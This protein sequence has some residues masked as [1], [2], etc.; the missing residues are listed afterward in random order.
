MH[1]MIMEET[2]EGATEIIMEYCQSIALATPNINRGKLP[3]RDELNKIYDLL[4]D[5]RRN[6]SA[7]YAIEHLEKKYSRIEY[8]MRHAM[9]SETLAIRGEGYLLHVERLFSEMFSPHDSF[10]EKHYGFKAID[11]VKTFKQLESSFT[12]RVASPNGEPHPFFRFKLEQWHLQ[13]VGKGKYPE[14][15]AKANPGI[16]IEDGKLMLYPLNWISYYKQLY[17]VR[18]F[19]S[20]QEKVVKCLSLRFGENQIFSGFQSYN[21]LNPSEIFTKPLVEDEDGNFYLFAMNIGARNYFNIAQNLIKQAD[22]KYYNQ[23]FIGNAKHISKDRFIER[24]VLSLLKKMLPGV[25]FYPNVKY[26]YAEDDF[27][28]KC[29]KV[30]GSKYELD[31][32]GVSTK[33]TY[34]VEV[35][36]GLINEDS[37]RGAIK[38]IKSDMSKVVGDAV[39]QSYRAYRYIRNTDNCIFTTEEKNEITPLRRDNVFRISV[40]FSYVGSLISALIKL[41]EFGAIDS[42]AEYAWTINIFDLIPFS[43]IV[44]SEDEFID[45]LT[46]R[47]QSYEDK[48]LQV[49]DE[50]DMLG[51]YYENDL[52]IDPAFDNSDTVILNGYKDAIDDYFEGRGPKPKKKT[53]TVL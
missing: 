46:K 2:E 48:R 53:S 30:S 28:L 26:K 43:E 34:V 24:K 5:I 50:I 16:I 17:R 49:V 4:L 21:M 20:T 32:L 13:T 27:N 8:D 11:I 52:K 47:L 41:K 45:Y 33:A 14:D 7:Y 19:S 51:L 3:G 36:A 38:S 9:I 29:A 18:H 39:C 31:I 22:E 42:N 40:S 44:S 10:F 12:L 35:K 6:L 1:S 25:T 15:F 37:K 23:Y